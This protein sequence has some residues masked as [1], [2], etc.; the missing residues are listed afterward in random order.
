MFQRISQNT[1]FVLF[2]VG[3]L[4]GC[5]S[6]KTYEKAEIPAY[7][8]V[9][10]FQL[11]TSIDHSQGENSSKIV[12]VWLNINGSSAG[13]YGL[14]ALIPVLPAAKNTKLTLLPGI[15][16]SGQ[17]DNRMIYPFYSFDERTMDLTPLHID[18]IRPVISY[19]KG[20]VFPFVEDF[21]IP[22]NKNLYVWHAKPG[23]SV[24]RTVDGFSRVPGNYYGTVT[25]SDSITDYIE[26]KM[27]TPD[28]LGYMKPAIGTRAFFEMDYKSNVLIRVG[29]EAISPAGELNYFTLIDIYERD[30]WNKLYLDIT[31]DLNSLATNSRFKLWFRVYKFDGGKTQCSF[32]DLKIVY[33]D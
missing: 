15:V 9:P 25:I 24:V 27:N 10:S 23:D 1:W 20:L 28:S 5:V 4:L 19:A 14:P 13:S 22:S 16:N 21:S 31:N 11:N 6:C 7:I 8:Y 18:T 26:I 12:D 29:M 33:F 3:I 2:F 30:S 17:D 32:D